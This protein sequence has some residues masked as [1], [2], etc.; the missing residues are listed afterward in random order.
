MGERSLLA[1]CEFNLVNIKWSGW[2]YK[3]IICGDKGPIW[4][5]KIPF[6][7]KITPKILRDILLIVERLDIC[8]DSAFSR[9]FFSNTQV[10]CLQLRSKT[11]RVWQTWTPKP[12]PQNN[13][14][15]LTFSA[16]VQK[17]I[18]W[19]FIG[20]P[21]GSVKSMTTKSARYLRNNDTRGNDE[22]ICMCR[23]P[24]VKE[25]EIM[26]WKFEDS[27]E[28]TSQAGVLARFCYGIALQIDASQA[29]TIWA[30]KVCHQP[31][32][33]ASASMICAKASNHKRA[34]RTFESGNRSMEEKAVI[35]SKRH[36]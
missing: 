33:A 25:Q 16:K 4:S 14:L 34:W 23:V 29:I 10:S 3:P 19:I 17:M 22:R 12:R 13:E 36:H 8:E 30:S 32:W 21:Q 15:N 18:Q 5:V 31:F 26:P 6:H 1:I 24:S 28:F 9:S 11:C 2:P 27:M 35:I 20:P 7:K